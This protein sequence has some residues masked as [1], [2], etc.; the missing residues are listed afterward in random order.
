M[1]DPD[2][3][4]VIDA[5]TFYANP[6]TYFGVGF[7]PDPPCGDFVNDFDETCRKPGKQARKAL[8]VFFAKHPE[9]LEDE[10]P[11]ASDGPTQNQP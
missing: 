5:L 3:Q 11:T 1:I 10:C 7:F 6:D 8:K 4:A 2:V 9:Y